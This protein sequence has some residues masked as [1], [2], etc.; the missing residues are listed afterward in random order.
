MKKFVV[1]IFLLLIAWQNYAQKVDYVNGELVIYHPDYAK[2]FIVANNRNSSIVPVVLLNEPDKKLLNKYDVVPYFEFVIEKIKVSSLDPLW[3]YHGFET[4]KMGN[5]GTEIIIRIHGKKDPV[6]GLQLNIYQQIFPGTTLVREKLELI[7]KSENQFS[8]NTIN[9]KLHLVFP[10]YEI[11]A[12]MPVEA[13]EIRIAS[14]ASELI[15]VNPAASYD[16]R[17]PD[18]KFS[19]YNLAYNH[20]F[21]P[22]IK[23]VNI[24]EDKRV[25]K[26]PFNILNTGDF[27]WVSAY[28]HASQ[29]DL[30]GIFK[31][32]ISDGSLILDAGQ[33][34]KGYFDFPIAESDFHFLGYEQ[35]QKDN[36]VTIGLKA[37]R[38]AYLDGEVIDKNNPY[39]TVWSVNAF[40]PDTSWL[41]TQQLIH[42]Y[43]F[44]WIC[45][46]PASRYPEFY[47]NTWGMQRRVGKTFPHIREIMTEENIIA[48]TRRAAELNVDI[49]VLDDGW[50]Q[51]QGEWKPHKERLPNGLA[52]I[53][54]E[55]DRYGIKLGVWLSPMGIDNTTI[56]YKNHPEWVIKDSKQQ[57]IGA[58]WDHPAFD[59]VSG[60]YDLFIQDCK[61]LIDEGVRFFK[62]DAI[63]SFYSRLPNLH[64]GTDEYTEEEIRARYEYLLPIYVTN[65]MKELTDYEPELVIEIDVTEAR[66]VMTGLA[67]LSQGKLFWMNNG[68]SGYHDYSVYRAKSMRSIANQYVGIVPLEL[69]TYANYPHDAARTQRYNVN[70]TLVAGHGFWGSLQE[71]PQEERTKIGHKVAKSKRV[72]PYVAAIVP[73]KI[74]RVGDSPEIYTQV[75]EEKGAGQV[76]AFSGSAMAFTHE[77]NLKGAN[78]LGVM[79]HTYEIKRNKLIINF[80]FPMPDA[81][82]E[83][84][85]IPN[86]GQ[87]IS[88][89][90]S[91]CWIDDVQ[92]QADKLT[93]NVGA[94]G[95]QVIRWS[96][97]LGEPDYTD[98]GIDISI[99]ETE[100]DYFLTV[101]TNKKGQTVDIRIP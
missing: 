8:L 9:G 80:Q 64:H 97:E 2:K 78:V 93:Y 39:S 96:K 26:G 62:W 50:E 60:Y 63:N 89:I 66:R 65:A 21:H 41:Q 51:A 83:A 49:F 29:D 23:P 94:A 37:L 82:R 58:Q 55:L 28:E 54:A 90:E 79:N 32:E 44:K 47:Y 5:R 73:Q 67:P 45:E 24:N 100:K 95:S 3:Q 59:F 7:T 43:L 33:G 99:S 48:E 13:T 31:E 30:R 69:F 92:L 77:V 85:I 68:A 16:E 27:Q 84:F 11:P 34:I 18:G 87:D 17:F 52:P 1:L 91:T 56:R 98:A 20:M 10:Q 72:L 12:N 25:T 22:Q 42:D 76:I 14:F 74:G 4:R 53:K 88:I 35:W 81:T 19:D 75:N 70:S 57:P 15:D 71:V 36:F 6:K 46:K 86:N 40:S 101:K 61:R 38:G